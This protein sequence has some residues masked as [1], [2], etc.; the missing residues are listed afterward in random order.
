MGIPMVAGRTF[1]SRDRGTTEPVAII[2]QAFARRAFGNEDP[3]GK[4]VRLG[5]RDSPV[6]WL[7]IV[8]VAGDVRH[9]EITEKPQPTLYR[10]FAQAPAERMVLAARAA[11]S[12]VGLT[13]TVR[14]AIGAVDPLQPVYHVTTLNRL[15]DAALMPAAAAMSMMSLLGALALMLATIGIYGVVSYAVSQQ[16]R[17]IGVRLTLGASP[18][19]V[20]RLVFR[21][22]L[23]LVLTG[24]AI[25]VAGALG[26]TR[27][28]AGVLFGVTP[29][30]ATTYFAVADGLIL[31][32]VGA[33]YLPAR[34]AMRV[35]P[36]VVLRTE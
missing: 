36:V 1:D 6:R 33:C 19:D 18:G 20:L 25:G 17:E 29:A 4:R 23:S 35:D 10:P 13:G 34:R 9:S 28:M 5:R 3:V 7:T 31:V 16:T 15:V 26:V 11:G 32:G 14:A 8:G 22:G 21:R 30:D 2:S 27:L 12:E 24:A